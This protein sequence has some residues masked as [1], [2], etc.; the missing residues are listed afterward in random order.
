MNFG[1]RTGS[2]IEDATLTGDLDGTVI[3][4]LYYH[5]QGMTKDKN[6]IDD[7]GESR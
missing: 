2:L 3:I 4:L 6:H 5:M 7:V 1:P